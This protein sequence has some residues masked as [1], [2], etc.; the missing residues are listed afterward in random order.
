MTE[1]PCALWKV[2][3]IVTRDGSDEHEILDIGF[4]GDL[5]NV[6]CIK[7]P[8]IYKGSDSPWTTLGEE[9]WNT[10]WRYDFVRGGKG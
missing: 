1:I 10:P 6:K 4:C 3:D 8:N 7:E 2:G 9:E 5:I